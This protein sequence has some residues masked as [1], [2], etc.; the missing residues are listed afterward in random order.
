MKIFFV[1]LF[2]L[3]KYIQ[4]DI[5]IS[6]IVLEKL[7]G[8]KRLESSF[9][10]DFDARDDLKKYKN[11]AL[12]LFALQLRFQIEDIDSVAINALTDGDDDKKCDLV[13]VDRDN[14]FI[15]VAQGYYSHDPTKPCAKAN[16][17]SDLNIAA[18]W[19]FNRSVEDL[20]PR[21]QPAAIELRSALSENKISSIQ[22]WYV[23]NLP[24]SENVSNELKTVEATVKTL[25]EREFPESE[26]SEIIA[27]EVG[28][29]VLEEWY[30]SLTTPIFVSKTF[31][32]PVPNGGFNIS[33]D[34]WEAF[35]TAIPARWLYDVFTKYKD[36]LFSSN[37]RGYLGSRKSKN[38]INN[39]IK[40]TVAQ[41]PEHFWV[42]NN[43]LTVLVHDFRLS[44]DGQTLV[45]KGLSIVNGAQTTGAIGSLNTRPSEKAM[46]PA[47]FVKC[48]TVKTVKG[49]IEYNNKQNPVEPADFRSSDP[50]QRRLC[51]EFKNIPDVTYNGG[52]RGGAEDVIRRQPSLLPSDTA[53]QVL[54]A[55]HQDP[56]LAYNEKSRI[57]IEDGLYSR[58][59]SEHTHADH[60]VFAYSLLRAIENKKQELISKDV[61]TQSEHEQLEFLRF[62]GATLLLTA[63][64]A[65]C[66]ETF[67]GRAVINSFDASFGNQ[68]SPAKGEQYWKP[69]VEL[70]LPFS[71]QLLPAVKSG[72]KNSENVKTAIRNFQNMVQSMVGTLKVSG[73]AQILD[74][75]SSKVIMR[76]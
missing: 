43:G 13:Y 2:Y 21:L 67:I 15:V 12:L 66:L 33:A 63:A 49:I 22:F 50:V 74:D 70:T 53:A 38:N 47:R 24:E 68:T 69:I 51:E 76:K 20:P 26:V 8:I 56:I 42:F 17:A 75:F 3:R 1:I 45:I 6:Q 39:G 41:D 60:I 72:L 10:A 52:R 37:I 19:L 55:F 71:T 73:N 36:D 29:K 5:L 27:I 31:E 57:W 11:N 30:R 44:E 23:H 16:K 25:V 58:F 14:G 32:V 61:L 64:I 35:V 54:A 40:Q 48:S 46:V 9:K 28:Q 4:Y 34:D 18:S 7:R 65:S 59:F 62:R